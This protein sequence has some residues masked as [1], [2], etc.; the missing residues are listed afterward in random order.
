MKIFR[1][2]LALG[3]IIEC[4][5]NTLYGF[6]SILLAPIFFPSS[7]PFTQTLSTFGAFAAGY[8][9]KPLGAIL[10]GLIGD[11]T[12][13]NLPLM[14]SIG[15]VGV[16]TLIIGLLPSY[17]DIGV[18]APIILIICRMMQGFFFG[19][20]FA[21]INVYIFETFPKNE[22]GKNTGILIASGVIGA[23]L[24]TLAGLVAVLQILPSWS[25]RLPFILGGFLA[26]LS[27][28]LREKLEFLPSDPKAAGNYMQSIR[29]LTGAYKKEM[30]F[31]FVLSG[32]TTIPLNLSTVY[33]NKVY[34]D[35]GF[36]P[37]ES[38]ALNGLTMVFNALFLIPCGRISDKIGFPQM[39]TR[40]CIANILV[41]IPAF[42]LLT[43][44]FVGMI[45]AVLFLFLMMASGTL[46]NGCAF[47]YM[48]S[49]FPTSCRYSGLAISYTFGIAVFSGTAPLIATILTH[50]FG[51]EIAVSSYIIFMSVLTLILHR[52][53][54]RK[55]EETSYKKAA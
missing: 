38:M 16:P 8:I 4:F 29:T 51:S 10:F 26:F 44:P 33:I 9:T 15:L 6:F 14:L 32:L 28:K 25:W 7:D 18:M 37:S 48:A 22:L 49:F 1:N 45:Q 39:I 41:S 46:I 3:H 17:Q 13:R 50:T 11:S 20:E 35:L 55:P 12:N 21:G 34:G 52:F 19:G 54:I 31:C 42:W 36:T 40:G 27:I 5:D 2:G 47:P 53:L 24:A 43:G 23:I 30:L